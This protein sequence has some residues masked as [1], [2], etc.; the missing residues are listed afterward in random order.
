MTSITQNSGLNREYSGQHSK[1]WL[2]KYTY[3]SNISIVSANDPVKYTSEHSPY[4]NG[5]EIY[6]E[7]SQHQA[8]S[9]NNTDGG[10][11]AGATETL[12]N[13]GETAKQY[14]PT[15]VVNALQNVGVMGH[16]TSV[17]STTLP[18][19][20]TKFAGSRGGVGTLPGTRSETEVAKLPDERKY[21][22][23][24]GRPLGREGVMGTQAEE[25]QTIGLADPFLLERRSFLF[26]FRQG[27][28][29]N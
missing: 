22:E 5:A 6:S 12:A 29:N 21:E 3:I 28:T 14:L 17:T 8:S 23:E 18:S 13:A 20:E 11:L 19:Q 15:G 27:P 4:Q 16:D 26:I 2:A 7:D 1:Q 9:A 10:F 25:R 24:V